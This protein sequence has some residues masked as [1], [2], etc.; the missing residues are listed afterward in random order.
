MEL[1]TP[2]RYFLTNFYFSPNGNPSKTMKDVFY[3]IEN[4]FFV[5]EIFKF[6]YF[7]LPLFFSLSAI[8]LGPVSLQC[9]Q[10]SK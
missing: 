8:A 6:L 10:T 5:L 2:V 9:H 3:F 7:H 4:A 1:K